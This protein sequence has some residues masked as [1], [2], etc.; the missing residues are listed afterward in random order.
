MSTSGGSTKLLSSKLNIRVLSRKEEDVVAVDAVAVCTSCLSSR[1]SSDERSKLL[2]VGKE[3]DV[4]SI[5]V[6]KSLGLGES[7]EL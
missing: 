7:N 1:S 3:I 2:A 5:R 4:D 6:V